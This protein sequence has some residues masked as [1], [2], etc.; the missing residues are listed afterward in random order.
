MFH[1]WGFSNFALGLALGATFVLHRR[2]DPEA[3]LAAIDEHRCEALVV[4]PVMLQR[5]LELP[6]DVRRR[7]DTSRCASWRR[8]GSALPG[9]LALRWMDAFGDNLY[10]LYGS[11]EVAQATIATPADLRAAPGTAGARR[12][13][14]SSGS[15]TSTARPVAQGETGRIFVGN[16]MLFEGY[17]GGGDKDRIDGLM[18]TGDVGRFDEA[19][20][21]FV[22]GRD[23]EMI[24]SGGENVFPK[25]VEDPL[26]APRRRRRGGRR[27]RRRREVRPAAARVRRPAS[28]ARTS[29][30]DELQGP[31]QGQ[32]RPLQGPARRR[33]P[34][35]AA[36]QPDRQGAQA[37][38][39][40]AGA[41][42][43]AAAR[44]RG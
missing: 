4:V 12:A 10:N 1:A 43:S 14:P 11:T 35:R 23:D 29:T 16:S 42:T 6:A 38:A 17:T 36:A 25:E 7:Y 3:T 44:R 15:S 27:R 26:I 13:A 21:L 20:R 8:A 32:P 33:L 19:G 31:R 40:C 37:G 2:F 30:A 24:V 34:R 18:A 5:I 28:P 9:D 39:G 41:L 22:Q